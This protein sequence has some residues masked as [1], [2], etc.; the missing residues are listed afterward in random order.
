MSFWPH[1][2]ANRSGPFLLGATTRESVHLLSFCRYLARLCRVVRVGVPRH[3]ELELAGFPDGG[4]LS[5]FRIGWL[6]VDL[7][8]VI[9]GFVIGLSALGEID[10]HG[11]RD[12]RRPF[13]V[14][15]LA[16]IV[17]LYYLTSLLFVLVLLPR[18]Y[19]SQMINILAHAM[20]VHNLFPSLQLAL[21]APTW[22]LGIELQFYLLALVIAPWLHGRLWWALVLAMCSVAWAW[23]YVV[24]QLMSPL[25]SGG[26]SALWMATTQLPGTLDEFAA[27]LLLAHFVRSVRGQTALEAMRHNSALQ[28]LAFAGAGISLYSAFLLYWSAPSFWQSV[29][30][31]TFVRTPLAISAALLL[32]VCC[33][34]DSSRWQM[35]ST[36]FRYLGTIS[37]GIYL[38][39]WPVLV[40]LRDNVE[41]TPGQAL[42]HTTWVTVSLAILSWHLFEKPIID[43]FG[44]GRCRDD[45]AQAAV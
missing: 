7:F 36:P 34:L 28:F 19:E 27:G 43:R 24:Y 10:R 33:T 4:V 22:S 29:G 12:F 6:G 1:G 35:I 31:V 30:T 39:H 11:P 15:R 13:A 20:F 18:P 14:R 45:G 26:E 25:P 9:S 44:R 32:L 2:L 5:W 8:F 21:N 41:L 3:R 37:Y 16:R 38:W 42:L 40:L 17:P 23:R